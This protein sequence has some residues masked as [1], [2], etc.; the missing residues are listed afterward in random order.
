MVGLR[1]EVD[2]LIAQQQIK[3]DLSQENQMQ[4]KAMADLRDEMNKLK[5]EAKKQ[6]LGLRQEV[7][8]LVRENIG[9]VAKMNTLK[10]ENQAEIKSLKLK[11]LFL[12]EH[13]QDVKFRDQLERGKFILNQSSIKG[14]GLSLSNDSLKASKKMLSAS[15]VLGNRSFNRKGT[16]ACLK[17]SWG[18]RFLPKKSFS[19]LY[20]IMLGVHCDPST[21]RTSPY[22][23]EQRGEKGVYGLSFS[24]ADVPK[25][26]YGGVR[27]EG[28]KARDSDGNERRISVGDEIIV[29]L[30]YDR[31]ALSFFHPAPPSYCSYLNNIPLDTNLYPYF[32]SPDL[33]FEIYFV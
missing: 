19:T 33:D 12:E 14:E 25:R 21:M 3:I 24:L 20:C 16:G 1:E 26:Y 4:L 22:I 5:Q 18:V 8:T 10:E 2:I 7:N 28:D 13:S 17:V 9:L 23:S 15:S 30:D 29:T 32:F 6:N 31:G 11:V 27:E